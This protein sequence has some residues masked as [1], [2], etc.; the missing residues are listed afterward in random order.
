MFIPRG[1]HL[2]Q[3][4]QGPLGGANLGLLLGQL[5]GE[6]NEKAAVALAL[7]GGQA[8]DA[9]QIVPLLALLLLAEVAHYMVPAPPLAR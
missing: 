9:G 2:A 6:G 3:V 7:V 5:V 8:E 4:R 1:S